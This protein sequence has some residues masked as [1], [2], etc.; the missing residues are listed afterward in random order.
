MKKQFRSPNSVLNATFVQPVIMSVLVFLA[1][2]VLSGPAFAINAFSTDSTKQ[3]M[4]KPTTTPVLSD[5]KLL[6]AIGVMPL[7]SHESGV[8]FAELT[9][10]KLKEL[11]LKAHSLNRCGG[12]EDLTATAEHGLVGTQSVDVKNAFAQ[13]TR[14]AQID[15]RFAATE[16]ARVSMLSS[17]IPKPLIAQAMGEV[18]EANL[19][20]TVEFLSSFENRYN[21]GSTP[22]LAVD[23][24]KGRLDTILKVSKIPSQIEFIS[25][26]STKQKSLRVRLPGATRPGEI[27]VLGGHLDSINQSW[28]GSGGAPGADDNASGSANLVEALRI[29]TSKTQN[30][31]TLD[32]IWYAGEELGL[33]GSAEIAK[34]YKDQQADVVAV[35]QLD[36]TLHPGDGEFH[37]GINDR[38]YKRVAER[39][40][41]RS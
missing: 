37:A 34:S 30:D 1:G 5:V 41:C 25:H 33:L 19:K 26:Q 24:L 36:M 3:S 12:F 39:I 27:I 22:N 8:G 20:A 15:E 10:A 11:T 18:S 17:A 7:A 38:F 9:A 13:F 4:Q 23:A 28:F 21:R 2:F 35:L 6:N 40:S 32:F 31:R 14:R 16:R 29:L